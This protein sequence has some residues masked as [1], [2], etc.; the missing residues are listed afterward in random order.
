MSTPLALALVLLLLGSACSA[1]TY[2][3]SN[4]G[5]DEK[6][7]TSPEA[8]W[9]TLA[10]V[11]QAD[12]QPGDT[13]LLKRGDSWREQLVPTSGSEDGYVTYGAYG[14]GPKPL[15]LGSIAMDDPADWVDE[16][17]NI[18]STRGPDGTTGAALVERLTQPEWG[19]WTEGGAD[20]SLSQDTDD[21]D[22][23]P[24]SARIDCRATGE[25]SNH[26][27][28]YITPLALEAGTLYKLSFRAKSTEPFGFSMPALMKA[29][30]PWTHYASSPGVTVELTSEWQ[31]FEH[32]YMARVSADDTRMAIYLGGLMPGGATLH[33]D[34]LELAEC[35]GGTWLPADVGNII[36]DGGPG[37]GVKRFNE[38]ELAAPGN[39]WFDEAQHVVKVYAERNPAEIHDS[40]ELAIRDHIIDQGGKSY[41]IYE[42]LACMYGGAHGIG[43]GSTHHIIVRDCDFGFIGGGDQMGG[44]RT[45]RYGN[46]IEFWGAA[47]D[48]LV[49][50]CRLWEIYDAALTN[51]S[52]GPETVERDIIY[53]NNIIWNCEYS[54]EYWNRP[55]ASLTENVRFEHN[56]C[57][58][59]GHGWGHTQRPDPSGRHLCF[60]TA[61][62]QLREMT[63]RNNIFHEAKTNAFYAPTWTPEQVDA[64][65]MDHNLWYQAEGVMMSL[66]DTPYAMAD[67][68]KYQEE[69]DKEPN[70]LI[71]M[72]EFADADALDFRLAEG[73][74]G[75]DAGMDVGTDSDFA[76]SARPQGPAPD[77]GAFER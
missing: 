56:T 19:F 29:G 10:H 61:P 42:N 70:S 3:V 14:E 60:Y 46:G 75:V 9:K 20:A 45:V 73:S 77:I 13:V 74:S 15:L 67:F 72:P 51:Q 28:L 64:L 37:C 33:I 58:N 2:Y 34:S 65:I 12:L 17:D 66:K 26:I 8:P 71:A 39:Y 55:E 16:G 69:R 35:V 7:G 23:A 47:H 53:R 50:R 6:E 11:N 22:S 32:Y 57:I 44:D 43:G 76:G 48:C 63:I 30:P 31:T 36:V 1:A 68:A 62:A 21:F 40:L 38:E 49:E 59:A 4:A 24:A 52:S 18:W 25:A 41:V 54:F 27:Q 5:S